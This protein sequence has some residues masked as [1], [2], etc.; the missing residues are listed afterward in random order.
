MKA[1]SNNRGEY[2]KGLCIAFFGPDGVGKS[3]VIEQLQSRTGN[4]FK[5]Y[6]RF[7]FRP[8]FGR[9][10]DRAPVTAP[11]AQRSRGMLLSV[12][13]LIYWL[14]DCWIGYF[15]VVL[16]ARRSGNLI[17]FDRYL[18]DIL[19]DPVRYRLPAG[20]LSFAKALARRAPQ[21][22]L[23]ILLDAP[24]ESVRR[25]KQEISV[26]ESQRQR[27]AY[28]KLFESLPNVFIVDAGRS[29]GEVVAEIAAAISPLSR[30]PESPALANLR[31]GSTDFCHTATH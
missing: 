31:S 4:A 6:I 1:R 23:Y 12:G 2:A 19:V 13:K 26:A 25:R 27:A 30:R 29:I 24:V 22:D 16:P 17:M 11:H 15:A 20:T 21:P 9:V 18:P 5:G 14:L 10:S 7:H 8:Y 3:A 28:R